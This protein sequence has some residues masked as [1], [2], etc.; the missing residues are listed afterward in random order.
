MDEA[1]HYPIDG[2]CQCGKITYKVHA[3]PLW[4]GVCHC[5]ECQK[6]SS[7][8]FSVT[9]VFSSDSFEVRGEES[10]WERLADN[11]N[12]NIAHFCPTCG[13]RIYH[14]NPDEPEYI[15]LKGGGALSDQRIVKPTAH[16]WTSEKQDWVD[17]PE[18]VDQYETLVGPPNS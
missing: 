18:G 5:K 16:V 14:S 7:S 13:N 4:V 15:R 12:R 10:Q 17:I 2:A 11:G 1:I 6:L 9:L 8:A 3:P